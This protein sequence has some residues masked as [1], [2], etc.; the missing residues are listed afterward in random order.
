MLEAMN[1]ATLAEIVDPGMPV[2]PIS[3]DTMR[4]LMA[5]ETFASG[6]PQVGRRNGLAALA[7]RDRAR[8]Y[9]Q[10]SARPRAITVSELAQLINGVCDRLAA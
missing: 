2:R 10:Q 1:A 7:E 5:I 4:M 3:A 6:S 8:E 9:R